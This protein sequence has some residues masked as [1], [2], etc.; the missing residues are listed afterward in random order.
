MDPINTVQATPMAL[1]Q[2]AMEQGLDIGKLE[3]LISFQE[4]YQAEG[5]RQAFSLALAECQSEI[6]RI[7]PDAFNPQTKSKY[8]SYAALDNAIRPVYSKHGFSLSFSTGASDDANVEILCTVSHSGGHTAIYRIPMPCDGKGAKGGE[9]MTRTHA[10]G[11]AMSYGMRY[12][13]KMIFNIAVGE[14]DDDGNNASIAEG[15]NQIQACDSIEDLQAIFKDL[16]RQAQ[17]L[18]DNKLMGVL[19][20]AKDKRKKE[21]MP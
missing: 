11:S 13:L 10:M 5:S 20:A 18:R 17:T 21:L 16:F 15:V 4:R 12:L 9:F 6:P 7:A 2:M 8:A 19:T 14:Y 3:R 1:V